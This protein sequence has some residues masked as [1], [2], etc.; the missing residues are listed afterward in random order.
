MNFVTGLPISTNWKGDS[1][2]SILV[3]VDWLTKMVHYKPVKVTIDASGLAKV[4]LNVVFR[5]HGLPNSIMSN[6]GSLFTSKFRSFLYYSSTS[7]ESSQLPSIFKR[8]AKSNEK[9]ARWRYTSKPLSTSNRMTG[10]ESC[11]WPSLRTITPK[12]RALVIRFSSWAVGTILG[13]RIRKKS[14]SAP[15]LSQ[16]TNYQ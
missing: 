14:T 15:S 8:T 13:C 9:T 11:Q 10:Q 7:N 12:M 3:I 4:I 2:D 16:W 5:Y 1:Y 6:R